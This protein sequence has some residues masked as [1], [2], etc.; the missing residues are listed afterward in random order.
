MPVI[1]ANTAIALRAV[2][3]S[4]IGTNIPINKCATIN[5]SQSTIIIANDVFIC[6]FV[7]NTFSKSFIYISPYLSKNVDITHVVPH[8][9]K[10]IINM[11]RNDDVI[12][13]GINIAAAINII[14]AAA[15]ISDTVKSVV[16]FILIC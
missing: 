12:I 16:C 2:I 10:H 1:E 11:L 3:S 4:I 15:N 5:T 13:D 6:S 9:I 8:T 14:T 7:P